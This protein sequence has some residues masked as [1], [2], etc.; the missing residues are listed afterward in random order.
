MVLLDG[1]LHTC[2]SLSYILH[3]SV[4]L[5]H[6]E[7]LL[8]LHSCSMFIGS[9]I[10]KMYFVQGDHVRDLLEILSVRLLMEPLYVSVAGMKFSEW[11]ALIDNYW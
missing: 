4:G 11:R 1:N 2:P 9:L 8:T 6:N 7:Y 5:Y 10:C 3:E